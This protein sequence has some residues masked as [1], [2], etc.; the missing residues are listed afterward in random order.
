MN[1]F[2]N[3]LD[4]CNDLGKSFYD[5]IKWAIHCVMP[6]SLPARTGLCS[7][8][9]HQ[10]WQ[11]V[12]AK[13][14]GTKFSDAPTFLDYARSLG[15]EGVQTS[16]RTLQ[17]ARAVRARVEAGGG[18]YE[19]D[20]RLPKTEADLE[21]FNKEVQLV[22]EA[23]GT[24]AR[25]V[26]T[27]RRRYETFTSLAQFREFRTEGMATLRLAEP[28][29]KKH[30][31]RLALEN[32]KDQ[33]TVELIGM[34]G[35]FMSEWIGVC[36]DTGNN[37]A[38]L[39]DPHAVIEALAPFVAS[40][41]F[42][43]MAVQPYVDGFLLSEVPLGAGFLDLPRIVAT[44]RSHNA[45]ITFN[46]EMA[47]RDPLKVPCLTPGY[48]SS[49]EARPAS[50]IAHALS[51]VQAHPPKQPPPSVTGKVVDQVL[52]EEEANNRVSLEWMREHLTR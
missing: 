21:A 22:R 8:S 44:L 52:A 33:L 5:A 25:A 49:F 43:D 2:G 35:H 14:P 11:A 23:G 45:G 31:V 41:H 4:Q 6:S 40:V 51:L 15:A 1:E 13:R 47:T 42:K 50:D 18:L 38:L 32:H 26:L 46:L 16:V 20:I 7:F 36:V 19:G 27:G 28:V 37:I 12:Q 34:L 9:C 3:S 10:Q 24:V 29:L 48:W 17:E 39:E 30:G